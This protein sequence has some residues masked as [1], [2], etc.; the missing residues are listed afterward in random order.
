MLHGDVIDAGRVQAEWALLQEQRAIV[1]FFRS[2][3]KHI[4]GDSCP[5]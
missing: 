1:D 3:L 2:I 4:I 5:S